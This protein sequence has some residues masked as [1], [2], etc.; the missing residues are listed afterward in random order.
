[1]NIS[2]KTLNVDKTTHVEDQLESLKIRFEN[3]FK[4]Q[5]EKILSLAKDKSTQIEQ[6]KIE[7]VE[8]ELFVSQSLLNK[9]LEE[10][11]VL[12]NESSP[13]RNK[14]HI[15]QKETVVLWC[16]KSDVNGLAK[17]FEYKNNFVRFI[18]L[19]VLLF[20]L[21]VTAWIM[22]WSILEFT[23]HGTVSKI[24]MIYERPTEFPAVTFCDYQPFTTQTG[25]D[26]LKAFKVF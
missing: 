9:I 11:C 15:S 4:N 13:Y 18:W 3:S 23:R 20:S 7:L 17:I 12:K 6:T 21:G 5:L 25:L 22:S 16:E 1:M 14:S 24:E 19:F 8:S 2:S 10:R 26:T